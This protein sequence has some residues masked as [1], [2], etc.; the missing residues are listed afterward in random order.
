M[1]DKKET[2][3]VLVEAVSQYRVR[4]VVEVP[5]GCDEYALDTVVAEEAQ[6]FGQEWLG[7]TIVSHRTLSEAEALELF[8]ADEPYCTSWS[9]QQ[10]IDIHFTPAPPDEIENAERER[11]LTD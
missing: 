11:V 7:E 1:T 8:R 9:D 4:Y 6:E 5:T 2:Q 10:I 3:W